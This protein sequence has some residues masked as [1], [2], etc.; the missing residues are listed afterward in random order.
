MSSRQNN[1]HANSSVP[2]G[3]TP[4]QSG[5]KEMKTYMGRQK[6][7]TKKKKS[8]RSNWTSPN[9]GNLKTTPNYTTQT[10]IYSHNP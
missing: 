2:S 5:R 7:T 4:S 1:G 3:H 10:H 9:S 8:Q 6:Q